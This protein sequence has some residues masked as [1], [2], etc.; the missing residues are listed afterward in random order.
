MINRAITIKKE[1]TKIS[2]SLNKKGI[3]HREA[4][5]RDRAFK[6]MSII[7]EGNKRIAAYWQKIEVYPFCD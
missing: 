2:L 7:T 3:K 5:N 1:Q 4:E 6:S